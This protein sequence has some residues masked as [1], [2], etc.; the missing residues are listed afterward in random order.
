MFHPSS[1]TPQSNAQPLQY[2]RLVPQKPP[3][4]A[5][6]AYSTPPDSEDTDLDAP[7]TPYTPHHK[8]RSPEEKGKQK[9]KPTPDNSSQ[10]PRSSAGVSA[11]HSTLGDA[12]R[13][14]VRHSHDEE[15]Y[16]KKALE[17]SKVQEE[18][19]RR[20]VKKIG[21]I[22]LA[23]IGLKEAEQKKKA[24]LQKAKKA[25]LEAQNALEQVKKAEQDIGKIAKE[26]EEDSVAA[27]SAIEDKRTAAQKTLSAFAKQITERKHAQ[28]ALKRAQNLMASH[29]VQPAPPE[30]KSRP[31]QS[32]P[33]PTTSVAIA[34]VGTADRPPSIS[35]KKTEQT[36]VPV[37][38]AIGNKHPVGHPSASDND[39]GDNGGGGTRSHISKTDYAT[40]SQSS[41]QPKITQISTVVP[42]VN[43]PTDDKGK[44]KKK[45]T[46]PSQPLT[47]AAPNSLKPDSSAT[48]K[49]QPL[50]SSSTSAPSSKGLTSTTQSPP[51]TIKQK[52]SNRP[53]PK[54]KAEPS[55]PENWPPLGKEKPNEAT[56]PSN[57][58]VEPKP[59]KKTSNK[60]QASMPP[61]KDEGKQV[62]DSSVGD[63]QGQK[64]SDS[65]DKQALPS[66]PPEQPG[67]LP[68]KGKGKRN[69]EKQT[70]TDTVGSDQIEPAMSP[71]AK[72]A[73]PP[74]EKGKEKQVVDSSSVDDE[75]QVQKLPPAP[76]EQSENPPKKGKGKHKDH[77]PQTSNNDFS[78]AAEPLSSISPTPVVTQTDDSTDKNKE[79]VSSDSTNNKGPASSPPKQPGNSHKKGKG[80][81][82]AMSPSIQEKKSDANTQQKSDAAT[83]QPG[84]KDTSSNNDPMFLNAFCT[85]A[86]SGNLKAV[87]SFV[88]HGTKVNKPTP[89]G[90][91]PLWVAAGNGHLEVVKYLFE[92]GAEVN[93]PGQEGTTPL[94]KAA[95]NGHLE[96][97][98]FLIDNGA[99][100]N[101]L[102]AIGGP[103]LLVAAE[104]GH[105]EVMKVLVGKGADIHK[106][107][108]DGSTPIY[109][110]VINNHLEVVQY[111]FE[112][113]ADATS[114]DKD[115]GTP[116]L[117]AAYK[118]FLE[119]VKYLVERAHANANQRDPS[120]ITPLWLAA[121]EGHLE[122]VKYLIE[123]AKET[124]KQESNL[125]STPLWIAAREG[126]LEVVQCLIE[127]AKETVN[128]KNHLEIGPL[129]VAAREGH[130]EIV[131]CLI[132]AQADINQGDG[133]GAGPLWIAAERGHLAVVK[134]LVE[135][136]AN[137]YKTAV[138]VSPLQ[139]AARKGRFEV[140]KYLEEHTRR[141]CPNDLT[142]QSC[143][144][145]HHA[146]INPNYVAPCI[147]D[148][149][150]T[151]AGAGSATVDS[152]SL[153][154]PPHTIRI[155]VRHPDTKADK[156][157]QCP[158]LPMPEPS[159][160]KVAVPMTS[161][162]APP[163]P[164]P[165][166]T[167]VE[168]TS[169]A[170]SSSP[171]IYSET[172]TPSVGSSSPGDVI[173]DSASM[174][175]TGGDKKET[176]DAG[177]QCTN[178]DSKQLVQC[179]NTEPTELD[180]DEVVLHVLSLIY[181]VTIE[182]LKNAIKNGKISPEDIAAVEEAVSLLHLVHAGSIQ[183]TEKGGDVC[184][185]LPDGKS[186]PISRKY[187][188]VGKDELEEDLLQ[189]D[190]IVPDLASSSDK[191]KPAEFDYNDQN[192]PQPSHQK[193][194]SLP[195]F[196]PSC[197]GGIIRTLIVGDSSDFISYDGSVSNMDGTHPKINITG[198]STPQTYLDQ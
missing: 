146:P 15:E 36:G 79:A 86:G 168:S 169:S 122:V 114:P 59:G 90:S 40:P 49:Q 164:P 48:S 177:P 135:S 138:G 41:S 171:S 157:D 50:T 81:K 44:G 105:L 194:E 124:V 98:Q 149:D 121:Q 65:P 111:L 185:T 85:A 19:R 117:M 99:E 180:L 143:A 91:T 179:C 58:Q 52:P 189:P 73:S 70:S 63:E 1:N 27:D 18:A 172:E 155:L 144:S 42:E 55:L 80:K 28:E 82:P 132:G 9:E 33:E 93:Q 26:K 137:V 64:F 109:V 148:M 30:D 108:K 29:S 66:P 162:S 167:P 53:S 195:P 173:S 32:N 68:K 74:L 188:V 72:E 89:E 67:N 136:G 37:V 75:Q 7:N 54:I 186:Y 142:L 152:S 8:Q 101:Q 47:T 161:G 139:V 119:I 131:Q 17:A 31:T 71:S 178:A 118:G 120:G 176:D 198:E 45:E 43:A 12:L 87:K 69:K 150:H 61:K 112:N 160:G 78:S 175:A 57:L 20:A 46:N 126:H 60:N 38:I 158:A 130:L 13:E 23:N 165:A 103:P 113:E 192:L 133:L 22:E 141:V 170:S 51:P 181:R 151:D 97:V 129:W 147:T 187:L 116:F 174:P 183:I 3:S 153:P 156:K 96:V 84:K 76:P 35:D 56:A 190:P 197:T 25:L 34:P 182:E 5:S 24:Y 184:I 115:G 196:P 62:R 166:S 88:E 4:E 104:R 154:I 95:G 102:S 92:N 145:D 21:D 191:A 10:D 16:Q 193:P 6:A 11:S 39:D 110:A 106:T 134:C 159:Q 140:I 128:Q 83:E 94:W 127:A 107:A 123:V 163:P 14:A 77:L 125:G 2:G 100:V